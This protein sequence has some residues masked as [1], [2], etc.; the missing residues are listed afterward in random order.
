[1]VEIAE[2]KSEQKYYS[3]LTDT[4]SYTEIETKS[5]KDFFIEGYI[6]VADERDLVDD[7]V[8]ENCLK[9]MFNQ[10]T[11]RTIT[12]DYEHEAWRDNPTILPVGKIVEAKIEGK[13]L[14]V[15]AKLNPSSPKFKSLWESIKGGFVNAFSIAYKATKVA[16][17]TMGNSTVRL[18][19]DLNL[20]NVALTGAP[21]NQSAVMTDYGF[22][23]MMTKSLNEWKDNEIKCMEEKTMEQKV[24]IKNC[25]Q[26]VKT[27]VQ[28]PA[29]TMIAEVKSEA[30][31]VEAKSQ[32]EELIEKLTAEMK[33]LR[34]EHE[35]TKKELKALQEQPIFKA[36]AEVTPEVKSEPQKI[37]IWDKIR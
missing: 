17:K 3:F 20:L 4:I 6:S 32:N 11:E 30:V 5:G 33:S 22:K 24:K 13:R 7:I 15:K 27:E 25:E 37:S 18:L 28:T 19:D 2:V 26:S 23:S 16:V 21:V 8:T 12:L 36:K 14:W 29:P 10:I 31:K 34:E 35:A 1:M 9:S